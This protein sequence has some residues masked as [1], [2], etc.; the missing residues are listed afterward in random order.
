MSVYQM[1]AEQLHQTYLE[2]LEPQR[3]LDMGRDA[4]AARLMSEHELPEEAAYYT[5]D[6]VLA[7]AERVEDDRPIAE[8][9]PT[10]DSGE[11]R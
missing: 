2:D 7:Y 5:T 4:V 8:P 6:Q 3:M 1:S 10:Q 11:Y 9:L